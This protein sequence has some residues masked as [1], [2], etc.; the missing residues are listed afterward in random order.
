M[1]IPQMF[2][3][4][5]KTKIVVLATFILSSANAFTLDQAKIV[6]FGKELMFDNTFQMMVA[7]FGMIG[8]QLPQYNWNTVQKDIKH[9]TTIQ[10]FPSI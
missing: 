8:N 5:P 6:L 2:S 9:H 4:Q 7:V 10:C 1:L 3:T